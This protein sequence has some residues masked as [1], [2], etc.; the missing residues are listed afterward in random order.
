MVKMNDFALTRLWPYAWQYCYVNT[1]T[2][3]VGSWDIGTG[4][5]MFVAA[6]TDNTLVD[7]CT[8][9]DREKVVAWWAGLTSAERQ[10]QLKYFYSM[11]NMP[12]MYTKMTQAWKAGKFDVAAC[13][14]LV[15]EFIDYV[16]ANEKKPDAPAAK[17]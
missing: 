13:D 3:S 17:A 10:V 4:E 16:V 1:E 5:S 6:L 2:S 9:P 8:L 15:D 12:G 7:A 14:K 11:D